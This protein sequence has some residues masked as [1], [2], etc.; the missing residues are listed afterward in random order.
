MSQLVIVQA[1]SPD[2][3]VG[4]F[5]CLSRLHPFVFCFG[6]E[7]FSKS[8]VTKPDLK[9]ELSYIETKNIYLFKRR[10]MLQI[11]PGMFKYIFSN[12]LRVV[13]LNPRC[14]TSWMFLISSRVFKQGKTVVWGH[15]LN[16][17]SEQKKFSARNAMLWLANGALFYTKSQQDAFLKT[18]LSGRVL[19]GYAPNSVVSAEQVIHFKQIGTD[20]IYV[21]R[22]VAEKK[23]IKLIEGFLLACK[24]GLN[25]SKL[26]I[27]GTGDQLKKIKEMIIGSDYSDRI[28]LYGHNN[29][30][31][32][33]KDLYSKCV[34]SISPGYVGLSI[35]QSF[36]FGKPMLI[37]KDEPHAPEIE[38]FEPNL[39]GQYFITDSTRDLAIK[40]QSFYVS[41]AFWAEKSESIANQVKNNYTYE[42]MAKG[43]LD[44]LERISNDAE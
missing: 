5:Q 36:S 40:L 11:W 12:S 39:N 27:V 34:C 9:K 33:L 14:I 35:T 38:A 8:V 15:L 22:L 17:A 13:E 2:Y 1:V 28:I 10:A 20:F 44:L 26:H 29:N 7:Y 41:R 3:R 19:S 37:S 16:R 24:E 31:L 42:S 23:P 4:L 6:D 18:K 25:E 43:Y 32:F 21:G 30:Y